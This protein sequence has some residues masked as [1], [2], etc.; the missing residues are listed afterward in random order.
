MVGVVMKHSTVMYCENSKQP[1]DEC[2]C[3]ECQEDRKLRENMK[4]GGYELDKADNGE[5]F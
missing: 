1:F 3:L 2:N 5:V 4:N